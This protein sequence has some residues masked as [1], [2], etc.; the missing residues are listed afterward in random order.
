MPG[1][2]GVI[3]ENLQLLS[4]EI[5]DGA[6][7]IER[8]LG[9]LE[10]RV[11]PFASEWQGAASESFESLWLQWQTGASHVHQ[12]LVAI[13]ELLEKAGHAYAEADRSIADAFQL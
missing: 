9:D 2:I 11:R 5:L 4:E 13:S 1:L 6:T 10:Q 8:M 7:T 12:A 3:P